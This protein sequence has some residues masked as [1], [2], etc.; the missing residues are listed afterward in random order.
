MGASRVREGLREGGLA[1]AGIALQEQWPAE[2]QSEES[3]GR[4]AVVGE[5]A[6]L[7]QRL[8]QLTRRTELAQV[9]RPAL[10]DEAAVVRGWYLTRGSLAMGCLARGCLAFSGHG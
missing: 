8:G 1:D 10:P 4:E 2:S 7:G 6:D 3:G 9:G 5:V